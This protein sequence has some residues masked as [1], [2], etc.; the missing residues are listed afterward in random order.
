VNDFTEVLNRVADGADPSALPDP[1]SLRRASD[2]RVRRTVAAWSTV[3]VVTV[4]VGAAV[5]HRSDGGAPPEPAP[6]VPTTGTP[7]PSPST[8]DHDLPPPAGWER[9][10]V[11]PGLGHLGLR[12][13][14]FA[15]D[16][17]VTVGDVSGDQSEGV[18]IWWSDDAR[19]WH[20]AESGPTFPNAWDVAGFEGGFVT[21]VP[22]TV[23]ATTAWFS[24]DGASWSQA[25][26]PAGFH[27][28]SVTSNGAGLFAWGDDQLFRSADGRSWSAVDV[29]SDVAAGSATLAFLTESGGDVVAG[30]LTK[31]GSQPRAWV[32][33]GDGWRAEDPKQL[34]VDGRWSGVHF[35]EQTEV[36]TPG[37]RV[38]VVPY[39]SYDNTIF[40]KVAQ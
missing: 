36:D 6:P 35:T 17:Y 10:V 26:V 5:V 20:R 4:A 22:H 19:T 39:S 13:V 12:A 30:T 27:V 40:L 14:T 29:P 37:L 24:P 15:R 21:V 31:D 3:A 23:R 28:F 1:A 11:Q 7:E 8:P 33:H 25:D 9:V 38:A 34:P 16:R 32:Q 18:P 2:R